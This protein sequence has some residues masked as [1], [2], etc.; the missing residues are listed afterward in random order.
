MYIV[1]L[2]N[3]DRRTF[4]CTRPWTLNGLPGD[5]TAFYRDYQCLDDVLATSGGQRYSHARDTVDT[6]GRG[7]QL[8]LRLFVA[9]YELH[10]YESDL[11]FLF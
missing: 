2:P 8:R 10:N 9:Q 7:T 11:H 5:L 4:T 6:E 1:R 3:I